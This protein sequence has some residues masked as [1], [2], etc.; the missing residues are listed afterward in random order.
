MLESF[1]SCSK[2]DGETMRLMFLVRACENDDSR[3]IKKE[4]S[5]LPDCSDEW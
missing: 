5:V 3:K 1:F 2:G 4:Q